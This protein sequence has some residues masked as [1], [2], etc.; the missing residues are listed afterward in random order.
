M[1]ENKRINTFYGS[2]DGP[3]SEVV[4]TKTSEEV[5]FE[6]AQKALEARMTDPMYDPRQEVSNKVLGHWTSGYEDRVLKN[7]RQ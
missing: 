7:T 4:L 1:T 5:R 3:T 6:K 2:F